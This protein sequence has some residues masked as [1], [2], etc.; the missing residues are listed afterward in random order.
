MT[1][2]DPARCRILEI[3]MVVTDPELR[4]LPGTVHEAIHQPPAVLRA[5]SPAVRRMH[6][7]SGLLER[8]RRSRVTVREAEE[9]AL[10]L[11][12]RHGQ[13]GRL[14]LAGNSVGTDRSFLRKY[15][16]RLEAFFHYR[17]IDVSTLKELVRRWYPELPPVRKSARHEALTDVQES[18]EELRFYR[19]TVFRRTRSGS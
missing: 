14:L 15:M 12:R 2:L 16:P 10:A 9:K 1:G 8:V 5:M 17:V 13:R 4:A 11:V 18:I 3:A 19:R 7:R 6:T